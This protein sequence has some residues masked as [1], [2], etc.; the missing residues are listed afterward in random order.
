MGE[1]MDES[2]QLTAA[3]KVAKDLKAAGLTHFFCLMGEA[4]LDIISALESEGVHIIH[5]RHEQ[6]IVAIADGYARFSRNGLPAIASVTLGPG[7]TNATTSI[8]TAVMGMSRVAILTGDLP[9][10]TGFNQ[11]HFIEDLG[12]RTLRAQNSQELFAQ[13]RLLLND[14]VQEQSV[15]VLEVAFSAWEQSD[16]LTLPFPRKEPN[17]SDFASVENPMVEKAAEVLRSARRPAILAGRGAVAAGLEETLSQLAY[18]LGAVI[19][20]TVPAHGFAGTNDLTV[21]I[22]GKLGGGVGSQALR[23]ADCVLVVGSSLS[24]WTTDEG[25]SLAGK[26]VIRL[27]AKAVSGDDELL[28]LGDSAETARSLLR[29]F[30]PKPV[31][32][33]FK[34]F[35][36]S[37]TLPRYIDGETTVD[38]RRALAQLNQ[39]LSDDRIVVLDG[40]RNAVFALRALE[41]RQADSFVW[42][43][44][45]GAIGQS[46]AVAMGAAFAMPNKRVTAVMGDAGFLMSIAELDTA[47]RHKLPLTV[48]VLN[49]LGYGHER[50]ALAKK[51]LTTTSADIPSPDLAAIARDYGA[52]GHLINSVDGLAK[53]ESLID[54]AAGPIVFDIRINPEIDANFFQEEAKAVPALAQ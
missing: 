23:E 49:D 17:S 4:N 15:G 8:L 12:V 18:R 41:I 51:N 31:S 42:T 16:Y 48:F 47:V 30:P 33:W 21:G 25:K 46:L 6:G 14:S 45:F 43:S 32:P 53:L 5:G 1:A 9:L 3:K 40:G 19:T 11:H 35:H 36:A 7:L 52:E 26:P 22:S 37:E 27:D 39:V 34:G 24:H 10:N 38:P 54:Q 29:H 50:G 28:V 2:R 44:D 20:T 13:L